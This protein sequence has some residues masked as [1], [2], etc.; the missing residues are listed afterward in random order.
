M[1]TGTANRTP[2][3]GGR[4]A[5]KSPAKPDAAPTPAAEDVSLDLDTLE[6]EDAKDPFTFKHLG[7]TYTIFDPEDLDW[8]KQLRAM[9]DPIYFLRNAMSPADAERFFDTECPAWK[10]E[11]VMK[12]FRKHFGLPDLGEFAGSPS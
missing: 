4:A 8:Q 1:S 10:L 2:A 6:R 7:H 12:T 11:A 5:A 9:G 3:R